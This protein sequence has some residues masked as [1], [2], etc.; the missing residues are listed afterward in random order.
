MSNMMTVAQIVKENQ[1]AMNRAAKRAKKSK[2]TAR[3]FLIRAGI[4]DKSGKKLAKSYR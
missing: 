1:K 2:K 4:L 3:S